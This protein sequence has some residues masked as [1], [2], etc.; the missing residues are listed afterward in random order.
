MS[1][2]ARIRNVAGPGK[3]PPS[4]RPGLLFGGAGIEAGIIA[5]KHAP[6][7]M[8]IAYT[9]GVFVIFL[10][11]EMHEVS[12]ESAQGHNAK[13]SSRVDVFRFASDTRPGLALL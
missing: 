13:Y 10:L 8:I 4:G 3:V 5:L 7:A 1:I 12:T 11:L 2:F 9:L 6:Q